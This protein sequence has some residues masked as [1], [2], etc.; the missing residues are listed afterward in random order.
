[1]SFAPG[2]VVVV[3]GTTYAKT[4]QPSF[5]V[6]A[7]PGA[8]ADLILRGTKVIGSKIVGVVAE[9]STGS[10]T[11]RLPPGI[12]LGT[13]TMTAQASGLTS[14]VL[15]FKVVTRIPKPKRA[16]K[17]KTKTKAVHKSSVQARTVIQVQHNAV[18][19]HQ[20]HPSSTSNGHVIDQ[21]VH[22]LV[23]NPLLFKNKKKGH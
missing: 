11:F 16:P 13:Y 6:V 22:A 14:N 18:Q 4:R 7:T 5:V 20:V 12:K 3:N 2:S 1:L 17:P 21:A 8:T 23:Q 15:S 19:A 9:G 10:S